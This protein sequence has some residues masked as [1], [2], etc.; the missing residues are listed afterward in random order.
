MRSTER[1]RK[2]IKDRSPRLLRGQIPIRNQQ[3]GGSNPSVSF[4]SLIR[5]SDLC[6]GVSWNAVV[7]PSRVGERGTPAVTPTGCREYQLRAHRQSD[8][9]RRSRH[10]GRIY[11]PKKRPNHTPFTRGRRTAATV[12]AQ[13]DYLA[14]IVGETR[15]VVGRAASCG[16]ANACTR[17]D[18][19]PV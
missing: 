3:L 16:S 1:L 15:D 12:V 10:F 18:C 19:D 9:P 11:R 5:S 2:L 14:G 17:E 13:L 4:G 8:T 7:Q 6:G